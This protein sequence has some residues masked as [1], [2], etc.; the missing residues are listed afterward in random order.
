MAS[1]T[2]KESEFVAIGASIGA[3]CRPCTKYHVGAALKNGFTIEEVRRAID[4]AQAARCE[5]VVLVGD[6]GRSSLGIE[7]GDDGN[8]LQPACR[9]QLLVYVGAAAGGNA[10]NLVKLYTSGPGGAD[11]S[12]EELRSALEIAEGVKEHAS[13]FFRRDAERLTAKVTPAVEGA[14]TSCGCQTPATAMAAAEK[15]AEAPCGCQAPATATAAAEG[16]GPAC[17]RQ[18]RGGQS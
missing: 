3:G 4:E 17:G 18:T 5:A 6:V 13:E 14:G 1:L 7:G 12:G 10:A 11:L 15:A 16:A 9:E 8:H 2:D